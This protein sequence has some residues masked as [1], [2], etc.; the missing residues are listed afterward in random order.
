MIRLQNVFT[1]VLDERPALI[2]QHSPSV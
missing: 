2:A 1:G